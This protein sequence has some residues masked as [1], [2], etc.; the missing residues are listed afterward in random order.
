MSIHLAGA[1][2][3]PRFTLCLNGTDKLHPFRQ[4]IHLS[5]MY[6]ERLTLFHIGHCGNVVSSGIGT[7][8]VHSTLY[9]VPLDSLTSKMY[10]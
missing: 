10:V 3:Y 5:S 6:S 4:V 1:F 2:T 9:V 7:Y 8:I